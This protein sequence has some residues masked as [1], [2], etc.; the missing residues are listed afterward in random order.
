MTTKRVL[1][2]KAVQALKPAP[3]EQRYNAHDALVPGLS[4]RVTDRGHK[5]FVL[6]ARFPG[7]ANYTVRELGEVGAITL[8]AARDKAREWIAQIK[9]GKDPRE[10]ERAATPDTFAAVA[11]KFISRHLPGKRKARIV[12]REIRAELIPIL[13]SRPITEITRGELI[14]LLEAIADRGRTAAYARNVY[15]HLKVLLNWAIARDILETSPCDR[16]V[17]KALFGEKRI[18]ERV[19][20]DDELLALWR[21]ANRVGYPF[22]ALVQMIMLTGGRLNE[23][24]S[25]QWNEFGPKLWTIPAERFKM[26]AVH[27]VPL[28]DAM[29][30]LLDTLPRWKRGDFIFT[31]TGGERPYSGFSSAKAKL[32]HQMLLSWRAIGRAQ[33]VD[34]RNAQIENWTLHDIRRT[35]RTRLSA[36]RVPEQTAELVIGHAKKGMTRV[37]DQHAYIDEMREALEAW[38]AKLESIIQPLPANVVPLRGVS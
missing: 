30:R 26:N 28:T 3:A 37:Y 12:E 23:V 31:T 7:S 16:I 13:G 36:L 25:A 22:G 17:P 8:A 21:G 27:L 9:A 11:E 2:D 18:R 29:S 32:D 38:N 6:G 24:A 35:V 5:T 14:R 15:G 4:V 33:G 1:T 34:R 19:L 10:V 20:S